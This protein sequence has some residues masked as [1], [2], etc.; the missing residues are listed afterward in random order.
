MKNTLLNTLALAAIL[1]ACTPTSAPTPTARPTPAKPVSDYTMAQLTQWWN[2]NAEVIIGAVGAQGFVGFGLDETARRIKIRM[3]PRRGTREGLEAVLASIDAPRD[4]FDVKIGCQGAYREVGYLTEIVDDSF[5]DAI[6][7]SVEAARKVSYG[8]TLSLKLVLRNMSDSPLSFFRGG[9][10]SHNFVISEPDGTEVWHWLCGKIRHL[11]LDRAT[12][13][14][15]ESLEFSGEWGQVDN[16]GNAV[17]AG[18]YVLRG[19]L[20]M[21]S[22][23]KLVTS[24]HK[25]EVLSGGKVPSSD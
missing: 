7:F 9:R 4:A 25:V 11:P 21:E 1:L 8:G 5:R 15:G 20:F 19:V 2:S 23:E 16:Q 3:L 18:E 13:Q 10:P 6:T 12:L 22:P 24:V 14:P 17:P